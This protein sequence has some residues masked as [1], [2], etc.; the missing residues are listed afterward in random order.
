MGMI[1]DNFVNFQASFCDISY[2]ISKTYPVSQNYFKF[3][4]N[5]NF[6]ISSESILSHFMHLK[7]GVR[8][9]IQGT[10]K[11]IKTETNK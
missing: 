1:V 2:H 6:L 8:S 7:G 10:D 5:A 3:E 11:K 4:S 9:Y